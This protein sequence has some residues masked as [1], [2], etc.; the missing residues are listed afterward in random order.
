MHE[1]DGAVPQRQKEL[2]RLPGV[3]RKIA[4]LLIGDAFGGQAIVVD[5][6]CGRISRLMGFTEHKDATKI[7]RDLVQ[8]VPEEHWTDWGHL[9]VAH[10]REICVARRPDC[11]RCP[12]VNLCDTGVEYLNRAE[13]SAAESAAA[14]VG[15][16]L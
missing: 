7:E 2:L 3:G 16:L 5:T 6:H 14:Q 10:G 11:D 1:F 4:N 8:V 15:D 13:Q 9:L 12:V